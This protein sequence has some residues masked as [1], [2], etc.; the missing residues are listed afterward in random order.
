MLEPSCR[1]AERLIC[2]NYLP[3]SLSL[4]LS[5]SLAI[6]WIYLVNSKLTIFLLIQIEYWHIIREIMS[7][8]VDINVYVSY[9]DVCCRVNCATRCHWRSSN[10]IMSHRCIGSRRR[11]HGAC[12]RQA[13]LNNFIDVLFTRTYTCFPGINYFVK[14]S[15]Y[16]EI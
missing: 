1:N 2:W 5:L 16:N 9:L 3:L 13:S 14:Y 15:G 6:I 8:C 10:I 11:K 4:S 7:T 12:C